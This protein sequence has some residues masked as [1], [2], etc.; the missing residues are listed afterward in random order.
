[1][2][3]PANSF[4]EEDLKATKA[5]AKEASVFMKILMRAWLCVGM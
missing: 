5:K 3:E 2:K 4:A 1:M